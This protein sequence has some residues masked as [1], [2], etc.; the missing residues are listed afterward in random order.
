MNV[1]CCSARYERWRVFYFWILTAGR[2]KK[3]PKRCGMSLDGK[4]ASEI[5]VKETRNPSYHILNL[6]F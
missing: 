2:L 5:R 1:I 6:C 4:A 3:I